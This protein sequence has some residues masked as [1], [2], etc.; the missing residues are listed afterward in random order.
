MVRSNLG[1]G[2]GFNPLGT[3][4]DSYFLV[5]IQLHNEEECAKHDF[6]IKWKLTGLGPDLEPAVV[7][8]QYL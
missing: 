8:N 6:G 2:P 3:D 4:N 7:K 5:K 1:G